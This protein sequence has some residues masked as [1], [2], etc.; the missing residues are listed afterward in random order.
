M[1]TRDSFAYVHQCPS[2]CCAPLPTVPRHLN[3]VKTNSS[4]I[5][6]TTAEIAV[7]S[8]NLNDYIVNYSQ[9]SDWP[10][11]TQRFIDNSIT[12]MHMQPIKALQHQG[13]P[14][15]DTA[16]QFPLSEDPAVIKVYHQLN[17]VKEKNT[18]LIN[19]YRSF[20][21]FG[22][23]RRINETTQKFEY[24][25]NI[26]AEKQITLV[27]GVFQRDARNNFKILNELFKLCNENEKTE[28]EALIK[29]FRPVTILYPV[30]GFDNDSQKNNVIQCIETY[31]ASNN[32]DGNELK[33]ILKN[34]KLILT[35]SMMR[36]Q[37]N[38]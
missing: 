38:F 31:L 11:L 26:D 12:D 6:T 15:Q 30:N 34:I 37:R 32:N 13:I 5:A 20:L 7:N 25:G 14:I 24:P 36:F 19:F 18:N 2:G 27:H 4:S 3:R 10:K 21:E 1:T 23:G 35:T 16:E 8:I 33:T 9:S 17:E 28:L 22:D 29:R